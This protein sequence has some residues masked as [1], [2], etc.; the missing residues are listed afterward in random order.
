M[1]SMLPT[2][3]D[4]TEGL[5]QLSAEARIM[6][7]IDSLFPEWEDRQRADFGNILVRLAAF[8]ADFLSFYQDNQ[9]RESRWTTARLRKNILA[10]A[11]LIG[12]RPRTASAA[13][14]EEVFTLAAA[15][16]GDL[17][18]PAGTRVLTAEVTRQIAY[19]LTAALVIPAGQTTATATVENSQTRDEQFVH[20]PPLSHYRRRP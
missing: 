6:R 20:E 10:F 14:A 4:Y 11:K 18:I 8:N 1:T 7:L 5:D 12:Y 13:T 9:A 19:Q 15:L 16:P 2:N 17:T 3:L